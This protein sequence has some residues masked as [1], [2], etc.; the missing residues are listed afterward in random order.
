MSIGHYTALIISL[1]IGILTL[2]TGIVSATGFVRV[3]LIG[4]GSFSLALSIAALAS[5]IIAAIEANKP[6]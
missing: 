1:T 5:H 6:K 4:V 3:L 2:T